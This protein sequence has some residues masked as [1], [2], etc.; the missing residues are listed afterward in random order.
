MRRYH[1]RMRHRIA[2]VERAN[3]TDVPYRLVDTADGTVGKSGVVVDF[4]GFC[5]NLV[6]AAH[7]VLTENASE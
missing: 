3:A 5:A 2:D 6:L 4:C 1:L 7:D